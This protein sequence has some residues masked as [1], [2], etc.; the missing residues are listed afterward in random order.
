MVTAYIDDNTAAVK[1]SDLAKVIDALNT[2]LAPTGAPPQ[3]NKCQVLL[4]RS[5]AQ[6]PP[7]VPAFIKPVSDG[8]TIFGIP[9]GSTD[10]QRKWCLNAL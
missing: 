5:G 3:P 1:V 10:Y 8:L 9:V 6:V 7:N 4:P 2:A